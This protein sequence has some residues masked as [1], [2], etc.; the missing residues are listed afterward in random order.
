ML[1]RY[2]L[3]IQCTRPEA[4]RN[5]SGHGLKWE[6]AYRER[7]RERDAVP[8]FRVSME[9]HTSEWKIQ[10]TGI[11]Q[12]CPLSPYLFIIVMTALF[13]DAHREDHFKM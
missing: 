1:L 3:D 12:G 4:E 11:R 5:L 10:E 2:A 9:G 8:Q 13:A 6:G 7:E